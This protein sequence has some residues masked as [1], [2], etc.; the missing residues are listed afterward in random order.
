MIATEQPTWQTAHPSEA[1]IQTLQQAGTISR[2]LALVLASRGAAPA[3]VEEF[4]HPSLRRL[5]DPYK[6]PGTAAP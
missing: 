3:E 5:S 4:L 6:L 2:P 1:D